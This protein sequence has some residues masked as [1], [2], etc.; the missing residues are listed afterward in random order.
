MAT[1][2]S[3]LFSSPEEVKA[4][5]LKGITDNLTAAAPKGFDF[6]YQLGSLAGEGLM[7]IT[8]TVPKAERRAADIKS[9][10]GGADVEAL[11]DPQQL[12]RLAKELNGKGY[13]K[14]ALALM[15]RAAAIQKAQQQNAV[16]TF[17][18]Q[19]QDEGYTVG[20]P[21]FNARVTELIQESKQGKAK[22]PDV[23]AVPKATA[24]AFI[25]VIRQEFENG[26]LKQANPELYKKLDSSVFGGTFGADFDAEKLANDPMLQDMWMLY[27]RGGKSMS[28]AAS[29]VLYGSGTNN[30]AASNDPFAAVKTK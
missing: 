23:T 10:M 2:I 6:G 12:L 20:T 15:D 17:G 22:E 9:V 11:V 7:G 26:N 28:E 24:E 8:G 25:N 19:A 16:S 5:R 14:E 27:R 13:T 29:S 21:A 4:A 3:G 18:K 30:V 1:D